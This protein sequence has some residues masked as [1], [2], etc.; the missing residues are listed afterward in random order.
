MCIILFN[1]G[2]VSAGGSRKN[3]QI[4]MIAYQTGDCGQA[5]VTPGNTVTATFQIH[6]VQYNSLPANV[7]GGNGIDMMAGD[8]GG[9]VTRNFMTCTTKSGSYTATN[10]YSSVG[11]YNNCSL[12]VTVRASWNISG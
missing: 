4:S 8:T 2:L 6:A 3:F 12:S 11:A 5:S 9:N 10:N 7:F 1:A